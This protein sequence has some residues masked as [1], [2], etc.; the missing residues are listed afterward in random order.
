M[1][2]KGQS[3]CGAQPSDCIRQVLAQGG[4]ERVDTICPGFAVDCLEMLEEMA[5]Q[6]RELFLEAGGR[7]YQYIPCLNDGPA[8]MALLP[9]LVK[10][11][12]QGDLRQSLEAFQRI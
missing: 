6:N 1:L 7:Q 3:S 5:E 8:Q 11:H 9:D 10:T 2:E 12:L 4:L